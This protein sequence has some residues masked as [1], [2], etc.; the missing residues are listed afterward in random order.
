MSVYEGK[1]VYGPYTRK[2]G[3]QVVI[4][5][6]PGSSKDHKTVSYPKYLVEKALD[7]YL[8]PDDTID[9]IDG[10]F[11]NNS[12]SNLRIV[13]RS[14]HCSSHASRRLPQYYT[15]PICKSTYCVESDKEFRKTCSSPHCVGILTHM[16]ELSSS[17]SP[18]PKQYKTQRS[19]LDSYVSVQD[20]LDGKSMPAWRNQEAR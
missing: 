1:K 7:I 17:I 20:I 3:R 5:K 12:F 11:Y 14:Q 19:I 10:N 16:P 4:L 9:H 2:D 13:S 15:C 18:D 6:T 8:H